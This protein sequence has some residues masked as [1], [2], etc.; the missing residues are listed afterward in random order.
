MIDIWLTFPGVDYEIRGSR[1]GESA[2]RDWDIYDLLDLVGRLHRADRPKSDPFPRNLWQ[3][4]IERDQWQELRAVAKDAP[5]RHCA[6]VKRWTLMPTTNE[7]GLLRIL[8]AVELYLP[9]TSTIFERAARPAAANYD[10]DD[11][12][13]LAAEEHAAN[14]NARAA[15]S[16]LRAKKA[17][18]KHKTA[19]ETPSVCEELVSKTTGSRKEYKTDIQSRAPYD[20]LTKKQ[21]KCRR[22]TMKRTAKAR[23][24][25]CA[26]QSTAE[27]TAYASTTATQKIKLR[28]NHTYTADERREIAAEFAAASANAVI[29]RTFAAAAAADA[30]HWRKIANK[31]RNARN[32]DERNVADVANATATYDAPYDGATAETCDA[33]AW[34]RRIAADRAA[35]ILAPVRVIESY[36]AD[37]WHRRNNA[38]IAAGTKAT[39]QRFRL[40]GPDVRAN[41]PGAQTINKELIATVRNVLRRLINGD[42][43][44]LRELGT[45]APDATHETHETHEPHEPHEPP[46]KKRKTDPAGAAPLDV[47]LRLP[48]ANHVFGTEHVFGERHP[49]TGQTD[50]VFSVLALINLDRQ[51]GQHIQCVN[52]ATRF[53]AL[54]KKKQPD[55]VRKSVMASVRCSLKSTRRI[56]TPAMT[57]LDL[58]SLWHQVYAESIVIGSSSN[59]YP[60]KRRYEHYR[61]MNQDVYD[62]FMAI[63]TAFV[64]GDRCMIEEV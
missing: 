4:L 10:S 14:A 53:W 31:S 39:G 9:L 52:Y 57:V 2:D 58:A 5:I 17:A 33:D 64:K 22:K 60:D 44:M 62:E 56:L 63:V 30:A 43:S 24:A 3:K 54:M 42:S 35:G 25:R 23:A 47:L 49:R 15:T 34:R 28:R 36:G 6:R 26:V 38:S 27:S 51:R 41:P 59:H 7:V 32:A 45:I 50:K 16:E 21:Q 13:A 48:R 61:P 46:A 20:L 8:D 37:E 11:K 19:Q 29:S 12:C 40:A 1:A 18:A 55:L